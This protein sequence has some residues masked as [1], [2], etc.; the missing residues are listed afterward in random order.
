M[1]VQFEILSRKDHINPLNF[2]HFLYKN[3]VSKIG[4]RKDMRLWFYTKNKNNDDIR[5]VNHGLC[6]T[7]DYFISTLC[8]NFNMN[9]QSLKFYKF[10]LKI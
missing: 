4:F 5:I 3:V 2:N 8:L 6:V 9:W 10:L 7:C 1:S